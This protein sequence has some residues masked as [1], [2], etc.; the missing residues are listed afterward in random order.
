MSRESVFIYLFASLRRFYRLEKGE[1][2]S[3]AQLEPKGSVGRKTVSSKADVFQAS[4][5]LSALVKTV[6]FEL[7]SFEVMM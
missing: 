3:S 5:S 7:I 1:G 2:F 6:S 4:L